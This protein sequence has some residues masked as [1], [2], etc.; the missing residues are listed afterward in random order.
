MRERFYTS[1]FR[2]DYKRITK[3]GLNLDLLKEVINML[4]EDKP[5]PQKYRDHDLTG[6]YIGWRECH[7]RPDWLLVYR[8]AGT[9][10]LYLERTGSHSDL[11]D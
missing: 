8:K 1:A 10:D 7:I 9:T 6:N 5:L 3:R 4:A 11:F 2:K